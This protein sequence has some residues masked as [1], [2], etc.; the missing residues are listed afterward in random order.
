[1]PKRKGRNPRFTVTLPQSVVDALQAIADERGVPRA[2][3]MVEAA[4]FY[5]KH[6]ERGMQ[7]RRAS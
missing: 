4:H 5:L 6:H 7:Q 1:M 3:V 2:T